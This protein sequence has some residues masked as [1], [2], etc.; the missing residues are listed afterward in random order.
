MKVTL[1][2]SLL[3]LATVTALP[4]YNVGDYADSTGGG[5]DVKDYNDHSGSSGSGY[6]HT[7]AGGG[8]TGSY[9]IDDYESHEGSGGGGDHDEYHE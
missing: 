4:T 1:V 5:H 3:Y 9:D 8:N 6:Q 2:A 7:G